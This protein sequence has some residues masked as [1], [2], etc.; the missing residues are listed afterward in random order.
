[1]LLFSRTLTDVETDAAMNEH[2]SLDP[3]DY[4]EEWTMDT[5]S[6]DSDGSLSSDAETELEYS[7]R[8]I[9]LSFD[10]EFI[11]GKTVKA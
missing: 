4:D 10:S 3:A 5:N 2:G 1:M 11:D 6:I 7:S 8:T 9:L